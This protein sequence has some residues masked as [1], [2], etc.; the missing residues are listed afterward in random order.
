MKQNLPRNKRPAPQ[1]KPSSKLS[2]ATQQGW[3]NL[4]VIV[5]TA[6]LAGIPF[7][8]GKYFEFNY[9]GPYD[10]AGYVYSAKHILDGAKI[11][12]DENP[13]AHIGTL[14]VNMLGVWAFGFSETGPKLIQMILQAAALVLMFIAM[15][16]LQNS[17]M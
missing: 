11:G 13:S 9:P 4:V 14:L 16:K 6:I 7:S 10:S 1:T 3:K 12:V 15:R 8:M 5:M 17:A 2:S